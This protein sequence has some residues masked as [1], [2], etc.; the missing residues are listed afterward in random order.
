MDR[1]L[2]LVTCT[3]LAPLTGA[4]DPL[5]VNIRAE[6]MTPDRPSLE[7]TAEAPLRG[8]RVTLTPQKLEEDQPGAEHPETAPVT[9]ALPALSPGQHRT[10]AVGTGRPGRT[11]WVGALTYNA[12]G[13]PYNSELRFDTL[14]RA[15]M[16]LSYDPRIPSE[17]L[18]L[19]ARYIDVQASHPAE[20]AEIRVLGEDGAE[21]GRG[22][23]RFAD[24]RPGAWLRVP[25]Q[26]TRP[27]TVLR[28]EVSIFDRGGMPHSINLSPWQVAVP[29][30]EVN[31][32]TGSY[33]ILPTERGKLDE[34]A[35]RIRT[36]IER[37]KGQASPR[38]FVAG[39]T[40]TVG[41]DADNLTLS[42]NRARAIATYLS[43]QSLAVPILY[44]G[45]GERAP[46]VKTADNVDEASN[47]RCDYI[48]AIDP[49]RTAGASWQKL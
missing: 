15:P 41:G 21:I 40:D 19:K 28:L 32:T 23:A 34:A 14:V 31:F 43:G 5:R 29:H 33:E 39:H 44:A 6:A 18:D 10:M 47:R 7:F 35:R 22:Q 48:L 38:L 30:E 4:A 9:L 45:F 1:R 12:A 2:V 8:L 13:K 16:R 11:M 3:L 20:R 49:P 27:G 17:H 42:Q 37:V 46:K 36:V 25:W 26:E 24:A